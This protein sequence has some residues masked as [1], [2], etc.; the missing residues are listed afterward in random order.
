MYMYVYMYMYIYVYIDIYV[1]MYMYVHVSIYVCVY[2]CIYI[3][4]HTNIGAVENRENPQACLSKFSK[5]QLKT[6]LFK[7]SFEARNLQETKH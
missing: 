6:L 4:I 1:Y 2:I 7:V 3:F 5:P